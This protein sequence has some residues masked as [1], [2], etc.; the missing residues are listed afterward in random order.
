MWFNYFIIIAVWLS[1]LNLSGSGN[2]RP[3][4]E[5]LRV[6]VLG[7]SIVAHPPAEELGWLGNWGM[8]ASVRDSDFVH[9]LERRLHEMNPQGTLEYGSVSGFE[10]EYRHFDLDLLANYRNADILVVKISE[11]VDPDSLGERQFLRHYGQLID[12]LAPDNRTAVVICDGFW[13][14]PVNDT[15]RHFARQRGFDFVQ[16]HDLYTSDSTNSARGLFAHEG[17]AN[18]P[19]DRGMAHIADRIWQKL[20][21]HIRQRQLITKNQL[22]NE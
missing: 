1:A 11:N 5:P 14:S 12:Y 2:H 3:T 4:A 18:H 19:S 7:N 10:R 22:S 13:P 9:R 17:V 16:L 21:P 8:A 20:A 6:V 15:I